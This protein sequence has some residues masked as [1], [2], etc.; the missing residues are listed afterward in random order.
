MEPN[1]GKIDKAYYQDVVAKAI[2]YKRLQKLI[3]DQDWYMGGYRANIITYAIAKVAH[4][5]PA[6]Q[7]EAMLKS[8]WLRQELPDALKMALFVCCRS[9]TECYYNPTTWCCEYE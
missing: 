8:I 2:I 9:G 3:P 1:I 4:D 5:V 6:Q 7:K